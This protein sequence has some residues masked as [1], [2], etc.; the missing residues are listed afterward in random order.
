MMQDYHPKEIFV[1]HSVIDLPHTQRILTKFPKLPIHIVTDRSDIKFPQDH[2]NA[3]KQLYLARHQG[4]AV[5]SCQG[6]G[7]YVCCQYY[8]LALVSDCHLECTYCILQDYLKNNPVITIYTNVD[9]VFAEISKRIQAQPQRLFRIGT[10]E[11]SDSLALDHIHEYSKILV[12]FARSHPN[13]LLELKT[14]TNNVENLLGLDH[15]GRTIVSW[16]VNPQNT[17]DREE[18]KC[19]SLSERLN[20]ARLCADEGYPVAFH[21]DPLL[22]FHDWQKEYADVVDQI[23]ARFIRREIAWVSIGSLRFTPDLKKIV[24]D[25]FPKSHVMAGELY[26]GQDGKTRYFRPIR[27]E[28]YQFLS[29]KI[30]TQLQHVP[31][32]LCMET[33][34]VWHS[35]YGQHPE[36]SQVLEDHLVQNF[37]VNS[38]DSTPPDAIVKSAL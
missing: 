36:N 22:Y 33:K 13:L 26:P 5:K 32:Y 20:A 14:K 35:V 21:F 24:N 6:M 9:E 30:R 1:D 23:A 4:Q 11:L 7:D 37:T 19:S 29:H 16:S 38:I 28:M 12:D 10:G 17:I 31:Y 34:T 27:E 3:K 2:S 18:H 25:R 15:R 8:T